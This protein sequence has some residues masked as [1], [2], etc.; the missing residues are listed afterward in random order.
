MKGGGLNGPSYP[1]PGGGTGGKKNPLGDIII[2]GG[3]LHEQN[4][5]SLPSV[6]Q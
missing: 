2:G 6:H 4:I 5:D 1:N 3:D